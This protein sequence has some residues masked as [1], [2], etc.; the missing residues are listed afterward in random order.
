MIKLAGTELVRLST[1]SNASSYLDNLGFWCRLRLVSFLP[2]YPLLDG[3]AE[4]LAAGELILIAVPGEL[5]GTA[6]AYLLIISPLSM[7]WHAGSRVTCSSYHLFCVPFEHKYIWITIFQFFS[8]YR[9]QLSNKY[10]SL[11][12]F[13]RWIY[14]K[15]QCTICTFNTVQKLSLPGWTFHTLS[16]CHIGDIHRALQ[17]S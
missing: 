5:T 7:Q 3:C 12:V 14:V 2:I 16:E 10:S 13:C 15:M 1:S 17:K 6:G 11:K 4:H 9:P 8:D